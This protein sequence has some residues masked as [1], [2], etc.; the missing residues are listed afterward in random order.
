MRS[1]CRHTAILRHRDTPRHLDHS[2]KVR[3]FQPCR[4]CRPPLHEV[5]KHS[6]FASRSGDNS[7][8]EMS[9]CILPDHESTGSIAS[10]IWVAVTYPFPALSIICTLTC[11]EKSHVLSFAWF[12]FCHD[13]CENRGGMSK[14]KEWVCGEI[15]SRIR[16][17]NESMETLWCKSSPRCV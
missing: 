15:M 13:Y 17:K 8:R 3:C 10:N 7:H 5:W 9:M 2:E 11:P 1:V 12:L 16:G 14:G 6:Q 4:R